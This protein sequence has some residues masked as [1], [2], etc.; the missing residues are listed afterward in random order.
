MTEKYEWSESGLQMLQ[1][2]EDS[3]RRYGGTYKTLFAVINEQHKGYA[4][5]KTDCEYCAKFNLK[6]EKPIE[7]KNPYLRKKIVNLQVVTPAKFQKRDFS[8]KNLHY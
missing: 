8:S 4:C 7:Y 1:D 2:I 5:E 6:I 3:I